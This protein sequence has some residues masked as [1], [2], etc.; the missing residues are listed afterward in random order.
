VTYLKVCSRF[1]SEY[2]CADRRGE[3]RVRKEE[4]EMVAAVEEKE[5]EEGGGGSFL[6]RRMVQGFQIFSEQGAAGQLQQR[7]TPH[8][9]LGAIPCNVGAKAQRGHEYR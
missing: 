6:Q 9:D 3:R 5:E 8:R 4:E 2:S 1:R 7:D